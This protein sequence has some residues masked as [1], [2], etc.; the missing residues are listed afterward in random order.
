MPEVGPI[1]RLL[2]SNLRRLL[3]VR[4]F[5]LLWSGSTISLFGDGIYFVT[6]AW[7]V[8]RLS[9]A[10]TALG[11][12]SAAFALPQ[13]LLLLLGGVLSDRLDRRLVMLLGNLVSSLMIGGLGTL[14]L[15]NRVRIWEIVM[16]V[17]VYGVSQA[18][19][20]PASRA[21]V[22]SLID[23]DLIPQ[24]MATEQ[25]VQPL[26]SSLIGPAIG[27]LLIAVGGTGIAFLIDS[28]TFLVAAAT[29]VAM[30][31]GQPTLAEAEGG[32]PSGRFAILTEARQG[33]Q[34][35]RRTPWIWA[36]LAAAG[37]ANIALTGPQTVL[38][39]YLV[40]YV[41]HS[42]PETLG[43]IGATG[44]VGAIL[45]ALYVGWRGVPGRDVTWIFLSWAIGTAALIPMGL[46]GM[47]WE[48]MPLTMVTMAGISLG[49]V[50]WSS[51]MGVEVPGHILGRV[52]GL[53]MMV[54]FSLTPLSNAVTGP[55]AGL[56][57]AR[58]VLVIAG[59]LGTVATLAV[60]VLVP[61]LMGGPR[62][63]A[64]RAD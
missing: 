47:A 4:D 28:G 59:A 54:S 56:I 8:Y 33:F 30:S 39:P 2:P 11:V 63:N 26:T 19:F 53:D 27:G 48:L 5:V 20:L 1:L 9:N 16:L 36:G 61:G 62:P 41:F 32:K 25:F 7:E 55:V 3:H 13:V 50:I 21:L 14:V 49:N 52:A 45:A 51:R 18:F 10:P 6:I 64:Q 23:P 46:A 35:V 42:G 60:L 15:L 38:I 43:L 12:V 22:P 44:G 57:G 29:L 37:I 58:A 24:A 17:A 31:P 40:K 34:L